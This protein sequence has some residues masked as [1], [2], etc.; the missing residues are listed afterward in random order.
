MSNAPTRYA[1][2][3]VE[4]DFERRTAVRADMSLDLAPKELE[5]LRYLVQHRGEVVT[6]DQ[7]LN[8]VWGYDTTPTTRTIDTHIPRLRQKLEPHPPSPVH[9]LSVYGEGCRFVD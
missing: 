9:I 4:I 3:G 6:R 2:E 8:E 1:L 7:L 5:V